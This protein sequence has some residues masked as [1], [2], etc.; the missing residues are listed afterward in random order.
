MRGISS[1]CLTLPLLAALAGCGHDEPRTTQVI[2]QPP[3]QPQA[4]T[5][6]SPGP[7]PPP[8]SEMVPP[9]P[10]G[11]GPVVWQPGHWMVNGNSWAWQSG[12]YTP[13]P[14]GETTWV[15]GRWLQQPNGG[16]F[17]QEGHWA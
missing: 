1:I 9:P 13:P 17:W 4:T 11:T 6:A 8:R 15:P 7:P 10:V 14:P 12:Q 16:W 2:V 5:M 3:T